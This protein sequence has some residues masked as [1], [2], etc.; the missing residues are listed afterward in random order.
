VIP[1]SNDLR[2]APATPNVYLDAL[3]GERV[4]RPGFQITY[5]L[6]GGPGDNF[7]NGGALWERE[8]AA[9]AFIRAAEAWKAVANI[10]LRNV[11][12]PYSSATNTT[13][14][15][16]LRNLGDNLG[17]HDL[18]GVYQSNGVYNNST[19]YFTAATNAKGGRNYATFLHEI[20]H[21]LGLAH[22]HGD[23]TPGEPSFPGVT[24]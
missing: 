2:R 4:Y 20:G 15:E 9:Q 21:G 22:P 24:G 7:P 5:V 14:V 16:S 13:W 1:T 12:L 6:R 23:I 19:F 10:D 17:E 18:P 11:E 8:G 3:L